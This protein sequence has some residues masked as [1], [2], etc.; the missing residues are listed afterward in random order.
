MGEAL[1]SGNDGPGRQAIVDFVV[2]FVERVTSVGRN[3]Y[4]PP[5]ERVA[6]FDNDGTLWCEK[7]HPATA[8]RLTSRYAN[9]SHGRRRTDRDYAWL[10]QSITKHYHGDDADMKVLMSGILQ[11]F[12]DPERRR[13][14]SGGR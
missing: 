5:D 8:P 4:V 11:A 13:A 10:G 7:L 2:D 1:G 14:R 6:V 3:E 9:A 12:A